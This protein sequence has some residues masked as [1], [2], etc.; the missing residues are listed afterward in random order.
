MTL[1]FNISKG[2]NATGDCCSKCWR[3]LQKQQTKTQ[4]PVAN[5]PVA[6]NDIASE[7]SPMETDG[8][9]LDGIEAICSHPVSNESS[10]SEESLEKKSPKK[11]GKPS[12]R[13]M[14]ASITQGTK[15]S[16]DIEKEKESLRNVTGGGSFKKI[17][18]I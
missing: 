8:L 4:E 14:M 17:D 12:Y 11:K 13:S 1:L 9:K 10:S 6:N 18:R 15:T 16:S 5:E 2:S 3:S 7:S